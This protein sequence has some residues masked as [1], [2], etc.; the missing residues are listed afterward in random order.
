MSAQETVLGHS[1]SSAALISSTTSN[2]L[3]E[4]R[5]GLES[6]SL[7]MLGLL[8]SRTDASQPFIKKT[9]HQMRLPNMERER[10]RAG[11]LTKQSWKCSLTRDAAMRASRATA[12]ATTDLTISLALGQ[13]RS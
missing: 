3:M 7:T 6:F 1:L 5:L 9:R 13:D 4:L 10:E 8:S 12:W 2:P 11:T